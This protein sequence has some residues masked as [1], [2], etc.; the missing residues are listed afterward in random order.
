ESGIQQA[1]HLP[2]TSFIAFSNARLLTVL[3]LPLLR[4]SSGLPAASR[5]R[6]ISAV[7]SSNVTL[8]GFEVDDSMLIQSLLAYSSLKIGEISVGMKGE[9][10]SC[11]LQHLR[12]CARRILSHP[13]SDHVFD[14][15]H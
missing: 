10:D 5:R 3:R 1:H 7:N 6:A 2:P 8:P 4:G 13:I 15:D 12:R 14:R 11:L 9:Q